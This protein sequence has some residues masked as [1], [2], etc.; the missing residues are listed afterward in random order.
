MTTRSATTTT[1]DAPPPTSGSGEFFTPRNMLAFLLV[2]VIW[3]STWLVIKDQVGTVPPGWSVTWRFGIGALA[4]FAFAALRGEQLGLNREGMRLAVIFGLAQFVMNFQFVYRAEMHVTSG[5]VA[6]LYA[7]L[8]VPNALLGRV[9]LGLPITR[10]FI[11]GSAIALVGIALLL[12]HEYR[13]APPEGQVVWG[14]ALTLCGIASASVAN[15]LQATEAARRQP[16]LALLAWA[17]VWG[18]LGDAGLSWAL[19][20]PPQFDPRWSY[21]AGIGYLAVIGSVV[22]FPLYF[23]LIRDLGPGRAAYNGV[24]VPIIAMLLSTLFEG[25]RWSL[26]AASGGV[27]ALVG[28][29]VALRARSPS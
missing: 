2:A 13:I 11:G 26:L 23:R 24:V 4:M 19:Y 17:M 28:L 1:T 22:T 18:T 10:G 21:I 25:Y 16:M 7:L 6:V 29:I 15:V 9:F 14:I 27:L 20:G 12:T 3:G 8:L 5:I